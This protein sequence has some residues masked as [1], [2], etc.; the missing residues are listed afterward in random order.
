MALRSFAFGKFEP[1]GFGGVE[2]VAQ[3]D[4]EHHWVWSTE[5]ASAEIADYLRSLT[6]PESD[7]TRRS[8]RPFND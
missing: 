6:P 3:D 2:F 8:E 5:I 1:A 7:E 4:V